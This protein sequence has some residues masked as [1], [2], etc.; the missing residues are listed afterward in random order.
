MT[1]IY[2]TCKECGKIRHLKKIHITD[3]LDWN[4]LI[5]KKCMKK[6]KGE[7]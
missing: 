1:K 4:I 7:K 6:N 2:Q 3:I 5:C